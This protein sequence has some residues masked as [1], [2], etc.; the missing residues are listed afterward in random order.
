MSTP[1]NR[2]EALRWLN[3]AR[4]DL[5]SA[6]ILHLSRK[7]STSCFLCQQAV[8]KAFKAIHFLHERDGWG[9]S[10]YRL[11]EDLR[12]F[13]PDSYAKLNRFNQAALLLDRLYIPTRYPNGLPD[14]IP[15]EAYSCEDAED[16]L[17]KAND[18]IE[19]ISMILSE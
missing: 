2:K 14:L 6:G 15:D 10:I 3:T 13:D 7:H 8:E 5:E 18:I 4:G 19:A 9:H 12:D 1:K 11:L 16:A 17:A